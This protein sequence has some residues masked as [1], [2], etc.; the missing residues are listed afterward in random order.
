MKEINH[1]IYVNMYQFEKQASMKELLSYDKYALRDIARLESII[2]ELKEYR[3]ELYNHVQEVQS[4]ATRLKLS[5]A[6]R[7]DYHGK[8]FYYLR[9]EKVYGDNMAVCELSE[10]YAGTERHKALARVKVLQKQYVGIETEIS[11]EKSRWER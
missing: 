9:I 7:K 5:L 2:D 8:V 11:I 10:T 6:R 3:K 1:H 4:I